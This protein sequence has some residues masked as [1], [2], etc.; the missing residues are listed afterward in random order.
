MKGCLADVM[1]LLSTNRV[2]GLRSDGWGDKTASKNKENNHVEY[3]LVLKCSLCSWSF[4]QR[5]FGHSSGIKGPHAAKSDEVSLEVAD[6]LGC[7]RHK[8][9]DRPG[10]AELDV[11]AFGEGS[12]ILTV[13]FS[14]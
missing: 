7:V 9:M 14:L 3:L 2:S 10:F 1:W 12:R 5:A 4:V 6:V 11:Y 8:C 13:C